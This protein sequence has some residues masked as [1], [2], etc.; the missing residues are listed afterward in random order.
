M[1]FISSLLLAI[2][3]NLEPL[4]AS[5]SYGI[6]KINLPKSTI[7]LLSI[8]TSISAFI[9]MHIGKLFLPF[10]GP[11]LADIFGAVL[12]CFI[13]VSF[14]I[15]YIRIEKKR[16]GYDTSYFYENPFGYR[17]ILDNPIVVDADKSNHIDIKECLNLCLAFSLNNALAFFAG[18]LTGVNINLSLLFYFLI[19]IISICLGSYCF[20]WL[21]FRLL[22]KYSHL[23][24]GVILIL[25]GILESLI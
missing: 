24:S 18:G 17:N 10:F 23:I 16:I 2:S 11:Q 1:I 15:E 13:G 3:S 25:L 20:R 22:R 8:L 21:S 9:S 12:L 19:S 7:I 5:L 14:I 4:S 6:K